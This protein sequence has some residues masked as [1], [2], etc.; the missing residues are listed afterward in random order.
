MTTIPSEVVYNP[1]EPDFAVNP[2]PTYAAMREN[3]PVHQTPFGA[4]FLFR[5]DDVQRFLRDPHMSV[6]ERKGRPG[7]M[8][9]FIQEAIGDTDTRGVTAMLNIDAPDHTRLRRLVSK[10][11]TP[12]AIER[13]RARVQEIV[14]GELDAAGQRGE[15]DL[16]KDLAFPLPFTV[17]SELLGMP[18]I[19][20]DQLRSWSGML[21]RT[22]EPQFDVEVIMAIAAAGEAM[23]D[24]AREV[25]AAKRSHPADDL[26]SALIAAEDE[27]DVLSD[28][29]LV[30]NV[31]LLYIAGHETTV[32]LIG[33]GTLALLNHRE[34]LDRWR[35]DPEL[36]KAAVD[37]LLRYDP[38]VQMSRRVTL[39]D[40][41]VGGVSIE[42][43]S[44]VALSLA[45][46]NR[47]PA[48]WGDAADT[49]DL[50]RA[51]AAEHVSFGG[52]SHYCL[53][54]SLAKLEAQVALGTMVRR[55]PRLELAGDPQWNGR[56]NLRGMDH[57]PLAVS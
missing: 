36:D 5:Y 42:A 8:D 26:L 16:I 9:Q 45:S 38:P 56:I 30:D 24:Y 2:Y 41:E 25:I 57:L 3:A 19:D 18:D 22:L 27:G 40:V 4:W 23:G 1:F 37:E 33:N 13:L 50:G 10:V 49:L 44:F 7:P 6:D 29:E 15:F 43:G 28:D 34:Q 52:G 46:A 51:N 20:H 47:D 39:Q 32:N 14:D 17:I 55:F 11:F 31:L 12:R 48:H 54:A 35:N 53:G 21:V